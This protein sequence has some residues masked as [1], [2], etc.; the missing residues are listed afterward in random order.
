MYSTL[1]YFKNN[2][3]KNAFVKITDAEILDVLESV[4]QEMDTYLYSNY[5]LPLS[6]PFDL[7]LQKCCVDIASYY[8]ILKRGFNPD[9]SIDQIIVTNYEKKIEFLK[10]INKGEL[11]LKQHREENAS[12]LRNKPLVIAPE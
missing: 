4:S 7:S 2:C 8:L 11:I 3:P 5:K 1:E 12:N 6:E 10:G 9:N